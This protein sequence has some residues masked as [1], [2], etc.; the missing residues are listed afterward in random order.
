MSDNNNTNHPNE[1]EFEKN[2]RQIKNILKKAFFT[3]YYR[4]LL[5]QAGITDVNQIDA[6]TYKDFSAIPI[7]SKDEYDENKFDMFAFSAENFDKV[8]Y[9]SLTTG[10]KKK[11]YVDDFKIRLHVTSGSTGQPL[12]VFKSFKDY[13]KDYLM[14]NINR[15]FLTDYSFK[16]RFIWIWPTNSVIQKY[17]IPDKEFSVTREVNKHGT[18]YAF[19]EHSDENFQALYDYI[20]QNNFEWITSSPTLLCNL[21]KYIR[22]Q[23]LAQLAFKYIECHS[24]KLHDWQKEMITQSFGVKPVSIY[25]SNEVQF[26]GAACDYHLHIFSNTCFVE[27]VENDV[28]R[29]DLIVTSL[30][31]TDIPIVRYRLGDCGQYVENVECDCALKKFPMIELEGFRSNDFIRGPHDK[32]IEPF[33]IADIFFLASKKFQIPF[34]RYKVKQIAI[35][36][37]E[38]YMESEYVTNELL[39]KKCALL[40][41]EVLVSVLGYEIRVSIKDIELDESIYYGNKYRY[42]EVSIPTLLR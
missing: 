39:V 28:G 15:K 31:Y 30:N 33:V 29:N 3:K 5:S 1:R 37:F 2:E 16:G 8:H 26:M 25:S 14:L 32:L 38:F 19:Y 18:M 17:F 20:A 24:E 6:M 10:D 9:Q 41:K 12:E 34:K 36:A 7:T 27:F 4:G 13:A 35:D 40:F 22:N 23:G 42:F 11:A 21:I